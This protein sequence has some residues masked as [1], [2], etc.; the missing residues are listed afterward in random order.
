MMSN[1][2][3]D[4]SGSSD[5]YWMRQAILLANKAESL[6]EV[7]VGAVL[8]HENKIIG[9]GWNQP[10][11]LNDPTAHAEIMA[12]RAGALTVKNYRLVDTTLYVTL[13][14]CAM[15]VGAIIHARVKRVVFGASDP[16][17]GAAG[18][19]FP[20]LNDD[21]FNH[22]VEVT[23]GVLADEC[24]GLLKRFFGKKRGKKV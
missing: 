11:G 22:K 21:K 20:L 18:S 15:C 16:K 3:E 10:I 19:V 1:D 6:D 13:E 24:G 23:G 4:A 12:L 7:P 14:P 5:E 17:T 9:E 2:I 8:V